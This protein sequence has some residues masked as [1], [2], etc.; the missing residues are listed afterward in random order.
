MSKGKFALGTIIGAAAG[1]VAGILT[2]PKS[3]KDTRAELKAKAEVLKTDVTQK[4]EKAHTKATDVAD[5]ARDRAT[6]AAR[7]A[8]AKA[9]ELKAR[10]E[11]AVD[12]ARKGFNGDQKTK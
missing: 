9:E 4:V 5:D 10:T 6:D 7:E 2:A 8:R 1:L 3:G 12:G 11:R